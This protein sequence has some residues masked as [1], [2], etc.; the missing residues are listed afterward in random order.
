M[1]LLLLLLMTSCE[2]DMRGSTLLGLVDCLL[3]LE[4]FDLN[5]DLRLMKEERNE[6]KKK[7]KG[8]PLLFNTAHIRG[9]R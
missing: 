5:L 1:L 7:K 6:R 8:S 4:R 2:Y 9:T 3:R